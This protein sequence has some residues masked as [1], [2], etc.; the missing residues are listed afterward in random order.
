MD[1]Q[2]EMSLVQRLAQKDKETKEQLQLILKE[3]LPIKT[4]HK[5]PW[6]IEQLKP[7][8]SRLV[9]RIE[10]DKFRNVSGVTV[11]SALEKKYKELYKIE[12][13][14][15]RK[16]TKEELRLIRCNYKLKQRSTPNIQQKLDP[17]G[18]CLD[19]VKVVFPYDATDN[20]I[21]LMEELIKQLKQEG[22]NLLVQSAT[23]TG[24]TLSLLCGTLAW[25][26]DE[27]KMKRNLKTQL[28]YCSR[29]HNQLENVVEDF[30]KTRYSK[31]LSIIT[32]GSR[33]AMGLPK[34]CN[35][36]QSGL[37]TGTCKQGS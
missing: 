27:R 17:H 16:H 9:T 35:C 7:L 30:G 23:G 33:Y 14:K 37:G 8:I 36:W 2:E 32:L 15:N 22:T 29:T 11:Q 19:S 10:V 31:S 12:K 18:L 13:Q 1:K 20:Q 26:Q 6:N 4:K 24:K 21:L 34:F 5:L 25:L 28:I 3:K